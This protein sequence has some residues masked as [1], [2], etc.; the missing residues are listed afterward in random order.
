MVGYKG[1]TRN[2]TCRG[3]QYQVGKTYVMDSK[4]I[5][6]CKSGF[7]FCLFPNDVFHYYNNPDDQYALIKAEGLIISDIDKS[8]TN[9]IKIE[10]LLTR[11]Q[12]VKLMQG[13]ICRSNC[14][15][16]WYLDG[17]LHLK[18]VPAKEKSNGQKKW[19]QHGL[20]H[21]SGGPAIERPDGLEEW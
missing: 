12:L 9:H 10:K 11:D 2:L 17:Q 7:H 15:K 16:K 3:F 18:D 21:R 14:Q 6:L 8:V 19:Y 20:L 13:C 1:F 4:D 5:E